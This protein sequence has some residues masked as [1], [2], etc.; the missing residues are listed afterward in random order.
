MTDNPFDEDDD[1][2][3]IRPVPGGQRPPR[4]R[5]AEPFETL[6]PTGVHA[7]AASPPNETGRPDLATP[8]D[9][10]DTISLGVNPLVTAAAPL[11]SLIGRLSRTISQPDPA[12]LRNQTL[13]QIQAFERSALGAGTPAEQIVRA[14]YVLC[15]SLDDVA[16]NSEWGRDG[17]WASRPLVSSFRE[18]LRGYEGIQSG[19]GFFR[20][21]DDAKR[22]PGSELSLL[23]LMYLC[24]SLGF[25]GELRVDQRP[26]A[27]LDR[28]RQDLYS[29]ITNQRRVADA[30]LSP[31][32]QGV[33]APY[34][35]A[36]A[37]LPGWVLGAAAFAAVGAV[38][39]WFSAALN[40]A[41]DD[42][43]ERML[44]AP[45]PHMPQV[46]RSAP[47]R[48]PPPPPRATAPDLLYV[49]LKPEIDQ[50]LVV[51][52]GDQTMPIVRIRNRGMFGSGS[53][54]VAAGYVR[55]LERI[56]QALKAERGPVRVVGYTDN[57]PIRTVQFPSN[58]QLSR[59]RADAARTSIVQ[60]LGDPGRVTAEGR[61]D[62]DPIG[63]NA[64]PEGRDDN[65]RIEVVLQRQA[66]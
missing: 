66:L 65:R 18:G 48:P 58:Y 21:L 64:T 41:S 33:T 3:V 25:L 37:V 35:P 12:D 7:P 5:S 63:S 47:V 27:S 31:H 55:L 54:T 8:P 36:R 62:A 59:A 51:V 19:V 15:A 4:P 14:R 42:L 43:Y 52:L 38:F 11:L 26:M 13:R 57:Q 45:L 44:A 6:R 9:G 56:G 10:A 23:E 61:A 1:K 30:D 32:W 60:A 22:S 46:V 17:V 40:A 24:L 34:R 53:A 28:I 20:L 49:F 39:I 50:G 16:Q 2:T 29:V